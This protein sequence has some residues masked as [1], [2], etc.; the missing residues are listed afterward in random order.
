MDGLD[1]THAKGSKPIDTIAV[2]E[3]ILECIERSVLL[4]HKDVVPSDYR[5]HAIDFNAEEYFEDEFSK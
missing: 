2:T 3:G 5:S 1:N 4:H